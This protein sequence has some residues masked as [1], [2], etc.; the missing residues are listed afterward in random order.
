MVRRTRT[1]VLTL[2]G[3]ISVPVVVVGMAWACGPSGYG[4]P[5]APPAPPGSTG[6][7]TAPPSS[8]S[9]PTPAPAAAP[10]QAPAASTPAQ[11]G[12]VTTRGVARGTSGSQ[13]QQAPS[14]RGASGQRGVT[15][16]PS[17][18]GQAEINARVGG[19]TAGVVQEGGQSVFASSATPRAARADRA[20]KGTAAPRSSASSTAPAVSERTVTGDLWGGVNS[21]ANPSLASAAEL[22]GESG[23]L[24]EGAVAAIAILGL[25]LAAVTGGALATAGRRRRAASAAGAPKRQ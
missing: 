20:D 14:Q 10:T 5:E 16:A 24:S 15:T 7:P 17:P 18:A 22:G 25:G 12:A 8:A 3:T 2:V 6:Q 4:V 19:S 23:G 9:A 13:G 1:G 11:S 21:R